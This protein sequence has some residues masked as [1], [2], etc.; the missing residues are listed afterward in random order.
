MAGPRSGDGGPGAQRA[1]IGASARRA[2]DLESDRE[3]L[4]VCLL[5]LRKQRVEER[6]ADLQS[7]ISVGS[8]DDDDN[9]HPELE[10]QF[11]VLHTR[12][13]QL[14][15]AIKPSAVTAGQRRS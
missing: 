10:R 12:R 11:Q 7:L 2:A 5:R 8:Q 3:E 9:E 4:R 14:E 15:Q 1:G 6:L 13:E